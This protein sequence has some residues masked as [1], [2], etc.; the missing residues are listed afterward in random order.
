MMRVRGLSAGYG[1][2]QVLQGIDLDLHPGEILALLGRNGAGRSTLAKALMGLVDWRGEVTW[3]GRSLAGL[4]THQLARLGMGYVPESR[5]VFADLTVQQ[6]LLLGLQTGAPAR[7]RA[8]GARWSQEAILDMFPALRARLR[9]PA[10]SLSGGEQQML[11]LGRTLLGQPR[12]LLVDEP[13]EGLAPQ[14]VGQVAAC[15]HELRARGVAV[16][17]IE[18]K[19]DLA[20][21]LSDRCL[22]MGQGRI[23][24]NGPAQQLLDEPQTRREWLEV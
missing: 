14:V 21:S 7:A 2:R 17:L 10:G 1:R 3:N 13:T 19:L 23:V 9:V 22:V 18:Q 5:D 4:A 24:F 8:V 11:T 12:L 20:L 16:L 6:N 15:L